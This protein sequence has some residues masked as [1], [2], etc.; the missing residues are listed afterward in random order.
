MYE[1]LTD[2]QWQMLE[3]F[4]PTPAKRSRG[5]PHTPW[6]SVVNAI[7]FVLFTGAKWEALPKTPEFASKSAAHR[8]YKIWKQDGMLDQML[9]KLQELS[10][11]VSTLVF[12]RTRQRLP[13]QMAEPLAPM[14]ADIA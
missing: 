11:L 13:K 6:R 8:W 14:M 1:P 5:K 7:L 10:G 4:F 3:A 12:P 2:L 9:S